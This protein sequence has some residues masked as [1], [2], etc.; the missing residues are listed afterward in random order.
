MRTQWRV[1]NNP[2]ARRAA[3]RRQSAAARYHHTPPLPRHRCSL[4][5]VSVL[6]NL[7]N[8]KSKGQI[9]N[10]SRLARR[11]FSLSA[12]WFHLTFRYDSVVILINKLYPIFSF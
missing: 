11:R 5:T 9:K 3:Q 7:K 12:F 1:Q 10:V 6:T 4:F 2:H 8:V